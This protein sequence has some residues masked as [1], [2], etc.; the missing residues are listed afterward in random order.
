LYAYEWSVT[1]P[2]VRHLGITDDEA[3]ARERVEALIAGPHAGTVTTVTLAIS[4]K[5]WMTYVWVPVE[6]RRCVTD[7]L[8]VLWL[9]KNRIQ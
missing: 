1:T 4:T 5:P 9:P 7:G 3:V 6:E 8:A 2:G